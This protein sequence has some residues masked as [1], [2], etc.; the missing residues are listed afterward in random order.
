MNTV[1]ILPVSSALYQQLHSI[2]ERMNADKKKSLSDEAGQL[3]SAL[4]CRL[5]DDIFGELIL[6]LKAHDETVRLDDSL[7]TIAEV[8]TVLNKYLPWATGFFGNERLLPVVSY[9]ISLFRAKADPNDGLDHHLSIDLPADLAQQMNQS[10]AD[11]ESG[12]TSDIDAALELLIQVIDHS[13]KPM[14]HYPKSL[15]KFNFVA[16]KTLGGV[17]NVTSTLSYRNIRKL[18]RQLQP[19]LHAPLAR[20][21]K[22]FIH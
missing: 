20:H 1:I 8:K 3:V 13:L 22:Q 6:S 12:Q 21:L 17:I 5:I 18:N 15:L 7:K 14:L 9:Y 19:H 16:D 4:A 2:H 10:L 11:L